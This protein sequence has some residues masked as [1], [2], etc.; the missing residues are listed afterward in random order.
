MMQWEDESPP[1]VIERGPWIA[2]ASGGFWSLMAPHPQ[3]VRIR[4]IAA[5]ISRTCRYAGQIR[6][7]F[8][9]YSVGE[10]SV[11][12]VDWLEVQGA[13]HCCE[14]GLKVLLHDGSEG[15][16][17]D[18][19]SPL[20]AMMPEFRVVE[21]RTQ[22]TIDCAFGLHA[23]RLSKEVIKSIDVRIRMDERE[24]LINE[25]ALSEQ[26]RVVWE[27]TPE[28]EGLGVTIRGL[29]PREAREAFLR[30]FVRI[31]ET[32]PVRDPGNTERI[33][34]QCLEAKRLLGEVPTHSPTL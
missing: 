9:F 33:E 27:H 29:S 22:D 14:D 18:M 20:K 8:D 15:Y 1:P 6:E 31:C 19:A 17:V 24:A 28:M 5:G 25:P 30:T 3:D 34:R 32:Y 16:L 13:I 10:H 12:M 7:E 26:K 21:N 4:D 23:A 2:T 11:L